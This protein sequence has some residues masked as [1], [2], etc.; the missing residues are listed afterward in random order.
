L[1]RETFIVKTEDRQLEFYSRPTILEEQMI[2]DCAAGFTGGGLAKLI[3]I[4]TQR[5]FYLDKCL[6]RDENGNAVKGESE[7]SV[8]LDITTRDYKMYAEYQRMAENAYFFGILKTLVVKPPADLNID[9]LD[10][11]AF[12]VIKSA[13][14]DALDNFRKPER[15]TEAE[16]D[17]NGASHISEPAAA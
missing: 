5:N 9:E 14:E 12:T 15:N 13:F 8:K 3:E 1:K 2:R 4:E 7:D 10:G 6:L 16:Q 11:A 17:N